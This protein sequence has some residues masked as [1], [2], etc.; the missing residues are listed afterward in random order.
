[1]FSPIFKYHMYYQEKNITFLVKWETLAAT[2]P[3][4]GTAVAGSSR[5]LQPQ[6]TS[7]GCKRPFFH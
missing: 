2:L 6:P 5:P 4:K 3:P 1:M 7:Q